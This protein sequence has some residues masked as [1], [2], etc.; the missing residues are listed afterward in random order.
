[1]STLSGTRAFLVIAVVMATSSLMGRAQ[2]R[3]VA[4]NA[5][6]INAATSASSPVPDFDHVFI[7][8]E[9]N[10]AADD[11]IG[12]PDAPYLNQLAQ[13]NAINAS[14]YAVAHPSL[15][16]YL[17]LTGG[18]TFGTT[19]DC[20]P[21]DCSV[22]ATNIA[23]LAEAA[24]K[25]WKAYNESMP[26]PCSLTDSGNY[27]AHHNPFLY[28]T[29]I[30]T[31]S[32]RC[33]AHDVLYSQLATDLQSAATTPSYVWITP[34]LQDDMHDGTVAEGDA[35]LQA[36]LPAIFNSPA[37]TTQKS[38]LFI[39]WDEDDGSGDNLIPSVVVSPLVHPG[40]VSNSYYTQYSIPKTI[41]MAWG[42]P[43]MT[44]NDGTA[45][46]LTNMWTTSVPATIT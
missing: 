36:N 44:S 21:A 14:Y 6:V 16:N 25:T 29:D 23:D 38:V 8:V 5:A 46:P 4:A 9:E 27:A 1:M 40:F 19:T 18:S 30:N 12:S 41:E 10:K 15:P 31:N 43:A 2:I 32:A 37:W 17:A 28:Y 22:S 24:G 34:N 20:L 42:L 11:I 39:L 3:A 33:D 45:Q 35:W 26:A 7:I 13:A